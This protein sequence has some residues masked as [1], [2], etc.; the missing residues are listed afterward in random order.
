MVVQPVGAVE[1]YLL[2]ARLQIH[3]IENAGKMRGES[4]LHHLAL[5]CGLIKR[6]PLLAGR[7]AVVR[8]LTDYVRAGGERFICVDSIDAGVR[9]K[10]P[11][12]TYRASVNVSY[13][14]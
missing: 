6:V 10:S 4:A 8:S 7:V 12:P 3:D 1:D 13:I 5:F 14:E 9:R 11:D 2:L